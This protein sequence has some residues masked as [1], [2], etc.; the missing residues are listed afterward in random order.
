MAHEFTT[1]YLQDSISLF[2]YYKVWLSVPW[3]R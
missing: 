2:K 3:I 1:S